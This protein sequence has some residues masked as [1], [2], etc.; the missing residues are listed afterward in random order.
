M[1]VEYL[2]PLPENL[3]RN[4]YILIIQPGV[5]LNFCLHR[6]FFVNPG[7]GMQRLHT[8]EG[9]D[10]AQFQCD[11]CQRT[12]TYYRSLQGKPKSCYMCADRFYDQEKQRLRKNAYEGVFECNFCPLTFKRAEYLRKHLRTHT[13]ER[14]YGCQQCGKRFV[15]APHLTAHLRTHTGVRPYVCN[16]CHKAFTQS[17]SLRS[18]LTIHER[19]A[20]DQN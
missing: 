11:Q 1:T 14:P 20:Q 3:V 10:S 15:Q 5:Q 13:G 19:C 16:V 18:H 7:R 6:F 8:E 12:F 2:V 4:T 9:T 17:K